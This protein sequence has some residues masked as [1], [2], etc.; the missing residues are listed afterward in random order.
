[1]AI[2]GESPEQIEIFKQNYGITFDQW[3]DN[4]FNYEKLIEPGGRSFPLEVVIDR[5]GFVVYLAN[6]YIPGEAIKAVKKA[7]GN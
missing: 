1:M 4:N 7:L 2:P 6:N 5:D 3:I